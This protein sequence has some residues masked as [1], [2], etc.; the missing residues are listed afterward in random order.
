MGIGICGRDF[1][2][3]PAGGRPAGG[4]P[5]GNAPGAGKPRGMAPGG[6]PWGTAAGAGGRLRD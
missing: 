6:S 5:R 1:R 4:R 2:G 3:S